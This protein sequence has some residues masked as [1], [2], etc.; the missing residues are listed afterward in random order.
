MKGLEFGH[1]F[2]AGM[3]RTVVPNTMSIRNSKDPVEKSD[4]DIRE[5]ALVHVA[6][7][8]AIEHLFISWYGDGCEYFGV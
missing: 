7:T 5:R 4:N 8:R 3:S 1:V 6:A 2:L